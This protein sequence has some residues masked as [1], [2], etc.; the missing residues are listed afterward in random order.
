[1]AIN[2]QHQEAQKVSDERLAPM[3]AWAASN[4]G[5]ILQITE[6]LQER[7]GTTLSRQTVGRWLNTDPD[8]RQEPKHGFG[9]LLEQAY[10][11]LNTK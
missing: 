7:T 8:K 3:R 9:L 11:A 1:M 10:E 2:E 6:W 4:R 5:S